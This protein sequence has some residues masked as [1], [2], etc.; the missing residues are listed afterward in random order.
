MEASCYEWTAANQ[1]TQIHL[2]GEATHSRHR[3]YTG[4]M[5][6]LINPHGFGYIEAKF[7]I[8]YVATT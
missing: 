4:G 1:C 8:E 5:P 7:E 2:G 3:L 6:P